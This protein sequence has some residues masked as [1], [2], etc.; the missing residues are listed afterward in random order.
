MNVLEIAGS[1]NRM[2]CLVKSY[3][4]EPYFTSRIL[5]I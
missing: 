5:I 2:S 1:E 3:A 4:V